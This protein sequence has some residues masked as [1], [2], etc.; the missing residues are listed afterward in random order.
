MVQCT[1][2]AV[3]P[4]RVQGTRGAPRGCTGRRALVRYAI[5]MSKRTRSAHR[6]AFVPRLTR[7]DASFENRLQNR[8][9]RARRRH[10]EHRHRQ[11][12]ASSFALHVSSRSATEH[13]HKVRPGRQQRASSGGHGGRHGRLPSGQ[14]PALERLP[15]P[16]HAHQLGGV[17]RHRYLPILSPSPSPSPSPDGGLP[18]CRSPPVERLA[19]TSTLTLT[20]GSV[21]RRRHLP[22]AP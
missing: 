19:P 16:R 21:G 10:G 7:V 18:C 13:A 9:E 8:I 14:S 11:R 4:V 6:G 20:L 22:I 17:G 12:A 1:S 15:N 5:G 3:G 2:G